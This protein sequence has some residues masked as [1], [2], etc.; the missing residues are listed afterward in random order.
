MGN[1]PQNYVASLAIW[2]DGA[3]NL[4]DRKMKDKET[5]GGGKCRTGKGR[6][7]VQGDTS[8]QKP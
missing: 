4:Q 2:N 3:L 6:T 1:P 8:Q 7:K 5:Y